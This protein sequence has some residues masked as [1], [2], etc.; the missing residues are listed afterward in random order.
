MTTFNAV[1]K[2]GTVVNHDDAGLIHIVVRA[3]KIVKI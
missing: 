1:F 3:G 2:N